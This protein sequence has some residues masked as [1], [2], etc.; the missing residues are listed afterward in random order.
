MGFTEG[1]SKVFLNCKHDLI[2]LRSNNDK[3]VCFSTDEKE[4]IKVEIRTLTWRIP[5]IY[6]SDNAKLNILKT[7]REG[8]MLPISFRSWH[9]HFNPSFGSTRATKHNWNVKLSVS[10]EKPRYIIFALIN[11][12]D[13]I[14]ANLTNI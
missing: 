5:H 7:I 1:F 13:F 8:C 12:N 10:S 11:K 9:S 14:H 2:L 3:N 6:L 4:K